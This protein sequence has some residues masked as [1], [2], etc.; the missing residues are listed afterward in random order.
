MP[1]HNFV[2][3][4]AIKTQRL[5]LRQLMPN[6]RDAIFFLRSDDAVNQYIGRPRPKD[7]AEADAF[8]AKISKGI[9]DGQSLYWAIAMPTTPAL[10]GTICLWNFSEDGSMAEIGY[11]LHPNYQGKGIMQEAVRAVLGYAFDQ[12]RFQTIEAYTN[13]H[14]KPSIQLLV[15][16]GFVHN[17]H[18]TDEDYP[19]NHIYT[20]TKAIFSHATL[21]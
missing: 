14:N 20:V 18:K 7:M 8:I 5:L 16:N 19:L 1:Q 6:D 21:P 4:P 15:K 3:F 17:P 9:A 13:L 11:E 12:L 2:P 10:I